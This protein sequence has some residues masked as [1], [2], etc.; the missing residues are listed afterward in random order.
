MNAI[1]KV[2][3]KG[4]ASRWIQIGFALAILLFISALLRNETGS[5]SQRS[6]PHNIAGLSMTD[7]MTGDEAKRE[8][9]QLHGLNI[10][11]QD[12]WIG[13][14]GGQRATVWVSVSPTENDST[15]LMST[16][17]GKIRQGN[18][19]F[20]NLQEMAIDGQKIFSLNARDGQKH[21]VYQVD[22]RVIW[23]AAPAGNEMPFV[24]EALRLL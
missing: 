10:T 12:A 17:I 9:N 19:Y 7:T 11:L 2:R 22:R 8:V 1:N 4:K 15:Y 24:Q 23:I 6:L 14:Y 20:G 21:Y 5:F 16:M 3:K 18:P 13:H